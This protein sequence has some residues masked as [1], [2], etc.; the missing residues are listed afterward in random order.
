MDRFL[1][2]TINKVDKKGRV[3]IPASFRPKL[4]STSKIYALMS[5]ENPCVDAGNEELLEHREKH[6]AT[7]NPFSEEY[8]LCSFVLHGESSELKIDAEGRIV[9]SEQIREHTGIKNEV[10][11]VGRG[12]FFQIWESG[13]FQA[14]RSKARKEYAAMRRSSFRAEDGQADNRGGHNR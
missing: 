4:G 1:S 13:R 9:V 10:A 2:N 11:F 6:L 14:Y 7:L 8:E 5:V 12:N 3:S